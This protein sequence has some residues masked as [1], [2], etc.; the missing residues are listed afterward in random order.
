VALWKNRG[1]HHSEI[2]AILDDLEEMVSN[3]TSF[4][5]LHT[6]RPAIFVAHLCAQHASSTLASFVWA[7]P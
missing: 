7:D 4:Q 3:F 5:V 2:T 1:K 6:K